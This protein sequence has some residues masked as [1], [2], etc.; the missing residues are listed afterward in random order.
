M[1]SDGV[2]SL[3][4]RNYSSK[5]CLFNTQ[6]FGYIWSQ[7]IYIAHTHVGIRFEVILTYHSRHSLVVLAK[8]F[9]IFRHSSEL[10]EFVY[11]RAKRAVI[12][13]GGSRG[14]PRKPLETRPHIN[15]FV[16]HNAE[17]V[18]ITLELGE[19]CIAKLKSA[20]EIF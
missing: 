2:D 4:R 6:F 19:N 18:F 12:A 10:D 11:N 9:R 13:S 16:F 8:G 3:I 17:I 5:D 14:N 15:D 20:D 1:I 7:R